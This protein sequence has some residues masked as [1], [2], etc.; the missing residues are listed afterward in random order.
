M[1][2]KSRKV[3]YRYYEIPEN[4]L[5]LALLGEDWIRD[6]GEGIDYLHFHNYLEAGTC[7][8]GRGEVVIGEEHYPF[9]GG[10]F[11]LIPPQI[12][13][14]T[15]AEPGTKAYW[16]WMYLD[17]EKVIALG[18]GDVA[19]D[20]PKVR[21]LERKLFRRGYY[22]REEEQPQMAA[23]LKGI[24]QEMGEKAYL[25]R[26][27][28]Q[29]LLQVLLVEMIRIGDAKEERERRE[30][31]DDMIAPAVLFVQEHYQEELKVAQLAKVCSISES[32]FRRVFREVMNMKPSDF[33]E[34]VR[35]QMACDVMERSDCTMEEVACRCGF[36]DVSTFTRDF[37]KI[38]GITPYR[39]KRT[40]AYRDGRAPGLKISAKKGW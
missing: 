37:K 38:L 34:T 16:E 39:W 15:N 33:I 4:E 6:Y 20:D 28:V 35:V 7:Y 36:G 22:F 5:V 27:S 19:R 31:Q 29:G 9:A 21:A 13:H 12:P 8:E 10:G 26:E 23:L 18:C 17:M 24:R 32:H 14:T 1:A 25:Y 40:E 11:V 2:K 30:G 3:E